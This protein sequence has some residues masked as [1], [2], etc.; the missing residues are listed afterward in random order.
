MDSSPFCKH[1]TT[2]RLGDDCTRISGLLFEHKSSG[3]NGLFARLFLIGLTCTWAQRTHRG[4]TNAGSTCLPS[5]VIASQSFG[6][7]W[8]RLLF[9]TRLGLKAC[10]R[11]TLSP[12]DSW[13]THG[14][15][16]EFLCSTGPRL[17]GHSC[18]PRATAA[19]F[20][21]RL[22]TNACLTSD[23]A[24]HPFSPQRLAQIGHHESAAC[25]SKHHHVC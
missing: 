7:G 13:P 9:S 20:L 21:L 3:H 8:V 5:V 4:F 2:S 6:F 10:L 23:C 18:S 22:P 24:D 14:S 16:N 12:A 19:M 17:C 25:A 1:F 11:G 15:G